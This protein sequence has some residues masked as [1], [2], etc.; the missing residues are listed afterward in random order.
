MLRNIHLHLGYFFLG[1]TITFA[2]SGIIMNHRNQWHPEKFKILSEDIQV[3][4]PHEDEISY[5]FIKELAT[6]LQ[7]FEKIEHYNIRKETLKIQFENTEVAINTKTGKGEILFFIKTPIISH[8]EFL[9]KN[10]SNWWIYFSDI[11]GIS[12]I[13]IAVTGAM[14]IKHGKHTFKRRGWKLAAAGLLFPILF[15]LFT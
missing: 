7:L 10:T 11:F 3:K 8:T 1:L 4:L 12:L 15:L 9:H 6:S 13:I 2:L 14:M 5:P